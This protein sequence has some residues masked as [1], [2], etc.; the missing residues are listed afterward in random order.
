MTFGVTSK[1]TFGDDI[2]G[3]I[4]GD[5]E[6]GIWGDSEGDIGGCHLIVI[7]KVIFN[8]T[9]ERDIVYDLNEAPVVDPNVTF[10]L[11]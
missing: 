5:I 9:L 6:G 4:R 8:M 3:D 10:M 11:H 7:F 2:E 1:V